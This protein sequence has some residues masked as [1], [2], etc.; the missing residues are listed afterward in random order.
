M[1]IFS[2]KQSPL[3][4]IFTLTLRIS[5]GVYSP[6]FQ[7]RKMREKRELEMGREL[8]STPPPLVVASPLTLSLKNFPESVH[9]SVF[10]MVLT[11][12]QDFFS[13]LFTGPCL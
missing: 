1:K 6:S 7:F 13:I 10:P 9:S 12:C 2:K 8:Y 5:V 4:Q 3:L 11:Q